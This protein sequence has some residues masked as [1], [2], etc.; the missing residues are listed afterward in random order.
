MRYLNVHELIAVGIKNEVFDERVCYNF[1]SDGMVRHVKGAVSVIEYEIETGGSDAAFLEL[2]QLSRKWSA[3]IDRWNQK[4]ME[5][6]KG[7][8]ASG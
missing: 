1:W 3:E 6:K 4:H 2:R 7:Y 8:G 5:S